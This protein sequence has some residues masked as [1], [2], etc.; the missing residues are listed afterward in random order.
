M[1]VKK[2]VKIKIQKFFLEIKILTVNFTI[3]IN[4]MVK[5]NMIIHLKKNKLIIK[6]LSRLRFRVCLIMDLN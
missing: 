5:I 3:K 1:Q 4:K 6:G 2:K